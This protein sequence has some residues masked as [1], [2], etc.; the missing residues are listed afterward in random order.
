MS[1]DSPPVGIEPLEWF[2]LTTIDINLEIEVLKSYA[3][4]GSALL[5][6]LAT[7]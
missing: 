4:K 6:V 1:E 7:L 2:L 3:K 5:I